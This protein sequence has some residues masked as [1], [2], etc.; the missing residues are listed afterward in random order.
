[1]RP[2]LRLDFFISGYLFPFFVRFHFGRTRVKLALWF[3]KHAKGIFTPPP[4]L[5]GHSEP[6]FPPNSR[7]VLCM[8]CPICKTNEPEPGLKCCRPCLDAVRAKRDARV[9]RGLC[10]HCGKAPHAPGARLCRDCQDEAA[11]IRE[12]HESAGLCPRCSVEPLGARQTR[13]DKC[14]E[15]DRT[16]RAANVR[17]GLCSCGRQREGRWKRCPVCR[18]ISR[19]YRSRRNSDV[20]LCTTEYKSRSREQR[21]CQSTTL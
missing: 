15:G 5:P 7:A 19:R 10:R 1:M 21:K 9:A 6:C 17:A 4:D 3:P 13:C 18:A 20:T 11:Y 12:A 2:T 16:N 14:A 8:P